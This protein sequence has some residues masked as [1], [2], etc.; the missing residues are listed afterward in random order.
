MMT[1]TSIEILGKAYQIKCPASE[2]DSLQSAAQYLDDKMRHLREQ[3][4]AMSLERLAII[5]ALNVVHQLLTWE[6]QKDSQAQAINQRLYA[7]Q[8]RIESALIAD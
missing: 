6:Q 7:L 4:G 2:I 8:H 3:G 1:E 5:A